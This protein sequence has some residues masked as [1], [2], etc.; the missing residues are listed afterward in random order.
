MAYS[1]TLAQGTPELKEVLLGFLESSSS[2]C[3]MMNTVMEA[4]LNEIMSIQADEACGAAYGAKDPNRVNSRNG[5]RQRPLATSVGTLSLKIPKLRSGSYFPADILERYSRTDQALAAAVAEMYVC[6][7]STRKVERVAEKL[8]VDGLSKDQVSRL[9]AVLDAGVEA[10]RSRE[11]EGRFP[12][13]FVDAT[14][15]K[16]RE[17]GRVLSK[18]LVTAI[19]VGADGKCH[20]LGFS[21]ANAESYASWRLF[22]EDLERRGAKGVRLVTSDAHEGL[23]RAIAEVW[24]EATWQ[25]CIVHLKRDVFAKIASRR[26]RE[27]AKAAMAPVFKE[28]D[29]K[30]VRALYHGAADALRDINQKA[31]DT[32]EDA[33]IDALAHLCFPEPHRVKIRTNNACERLNAELKRRARV[34]QAFPSAESAIRLLGA[35]C[36]QQDQDWQT[37]RRFMGMGSLKPMLEDG[38]KAEDLA[39]IRCD[40]EL[41]RSARVIIT[42]ALDNL[43]HSEMSMAA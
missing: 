5:Y 29:P 31:A 19:G 35:V 10:L 22:L 40:E 42:R 28:T 33:E 20:I 11:I 32:W 6:G 3:E 14:Y 26:D 7:V 37:T 13:V 15:V 41:E 34:V 39:H 43:N 1:S 27:R 38:W 21:C 36:E 4:V 30:L 24:P 12:Y 25:R 18:A 8:G 9:C 16:C 2:L 23:R 17:A